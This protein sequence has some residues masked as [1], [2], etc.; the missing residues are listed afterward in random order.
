MP[1]TVSEM[2]ADAKA[3]VPAITPEEA[4]KLDGV[5]FLPDCATGRGRAV[6]QGRRGGE[7]PQGHVGIRGGPDKPSL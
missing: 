6:R 7:H 4:A 3:K 5:L 1:Q 2:V